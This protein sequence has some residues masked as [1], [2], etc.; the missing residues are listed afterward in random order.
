[1]T[2]TKTSEVPL[3][4]KSPFEMRV[5]LGDEVGDTDVRSALKT[6]VTSYKGKA[7]PA[8]AQDLEKVSAERSQLAAS[9]ARFQKEYEQTRTQFDADKARWIEL[10]GSAK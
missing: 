1:M 2:E 9:V 5:H 4:A 10:R 6:A 3:E 7:P 8:V